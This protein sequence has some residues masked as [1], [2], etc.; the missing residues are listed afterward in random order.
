MNK[1]E[2]ELIVD[3]KLLA[4][5]WTKEDNGKDAKFIANSL[6]NDKKRWQ[7]MYALHHEKSGVWTKQTENNRICYLEVASVGI[8]K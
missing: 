8:P 4:R 5:F 7:L 2:M 3:G 1:Y 6:L